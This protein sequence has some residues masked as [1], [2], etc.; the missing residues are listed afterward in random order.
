[1]HEIVCEICVIWQGIIIPGCDAVLVVHGSGRKHIR[2]LSIFYLKLLYIMTTRHRNLR[3]YLITY[4]S[5]MH[6]IHSCFSYLYFILLA[7]LL[8]YY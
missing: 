7:Y 5:V 2:S 1:M 6:N 4:H 3:V 8:S